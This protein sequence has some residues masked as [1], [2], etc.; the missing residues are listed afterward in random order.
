METS[1]AFTGGDNPAPSAMAAWVAA[2]EAL[3]A[4]SRGT[5]PLAEIAPD[6]AAESTTWAAWYTR[7]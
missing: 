1:P 7:Q 3:T 6:R 4:G 2:S 5:T